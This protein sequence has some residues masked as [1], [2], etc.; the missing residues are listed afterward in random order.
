MT[1]SFGVSSESLCKDLILDHLNNVI[2][3]SPGKE[4]YMKHQIKPVLLEKFPGLLTDD[5]MDPAHDLR[6]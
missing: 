2:G 4:S 1:Q 5:E 3:A 6:T